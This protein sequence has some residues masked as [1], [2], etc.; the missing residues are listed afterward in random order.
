MVHGWVSRW[1]GELVGG[2]VILHT[3]I[4]HIT[5]EYLQPISCTR[6]KEPSCCPRTNGRYKMFIEQIDHISGVYLF[7]NQT[8]SGSW[9]CHKHVSGIDQWVWLTPRHHSDAVLECTH[10]GMTILECECIILK[11]AHYSR[12]VGQHCLC[13]HQYVGIVMSLVIFIKYN[14]N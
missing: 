10:Q 14:C 7:V 12:D 4:C 9:K 2:W 1:V 3:C 6:S 11:F 5:T 8:W 13:P